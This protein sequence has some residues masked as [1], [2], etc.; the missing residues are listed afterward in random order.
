MNLGVDVS[1]SS[2]VVYP[3]SILALSLSGAPP[4]L[5]GLD[6]LCSFCHCAA[7]CC[8]PVRF[9]VPGYSHRA[10]QSLGAEGPLTPTLHNTQVSFILS[11]IVSFILSFD[12]P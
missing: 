11:F 3:W 4:S 2:I 10:D 7:V 5:P 12:F 8:V 1:G 9:P 6:I